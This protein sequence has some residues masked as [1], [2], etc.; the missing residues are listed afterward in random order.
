M[1]IS[2]LFSFLSWIFFAILLYFVLRNERAGIKRYIR[3]RIGRQNECFA[4]LTAR[5]EALENAPE[6]QPK[7]NEK[8]TKSRNPNP[9]L[10]SQD[11]HAEEIREKE[12]V[13]V[14]GK[15]VRKDQAFKFDS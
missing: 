7:D 10:G 5:I 15:I 2:I 12:V 11:R 13:V 9:L 3:Y 4:R 14:D 6:K 1:Y 8:Q